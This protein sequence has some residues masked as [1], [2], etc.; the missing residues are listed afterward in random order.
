M[1]KDAFKNKVQSWDR[2]PD[3]WYQEPAWPSER[4]FAVEAFE[5]RVVDP[6]AGSGTVVRSAK[7]AGLSAEGYDLH[8]RGFAH[9]RGGLDFM[10]PADPYLHGTWPADNIVSNPPYATWAQVGRLRPNGA[11]DRLDEEFLRVALTRA[12]SKV[13]IFMLSGWI[14]SAKRSAWIE[15]LPLYREYRCTPRPSCPPGTYLQAGNKA[16]N[17][18]NDYSWFVFLKGFTGSPTI[19][20][21]RGGA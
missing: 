1:A 19:H 9:V 18:K 7:A 8:D 17:G 4:L 14:N 20:W 12:R 13:A 21:L 10:D 5:G 3:A 6:C 15:T 11:K 2:D 16:G